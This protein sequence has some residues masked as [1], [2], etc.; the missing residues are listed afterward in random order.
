MTSGYVHGLYMKPKWFMLKI[1]LY[2]Q[3][4]FS[5]IC[6]SLKIQNTSIPQT[7]LTKRLSNKIIFL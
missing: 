7:L 2:V 6:K 4:S 3:E 5:C 1:G